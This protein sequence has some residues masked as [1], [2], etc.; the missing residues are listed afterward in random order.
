M[1][2]KKMLMLAVSAIFC[3]AM[4]FPAM[5]DTIS[6]ISMRI[7]SNI[8]AGDDDSDV[9]V[10]TDS[11]KYSVEKVNVT[12]T[13]SRGWDEGDRPKLTIWI[14]AE[15][16]NTFSSNFSKSDVS[17]KGDG[18]TVNF[19][20]R[21]KDYITVNVTLDKLGSS[22]NDYDLDVS[23]L[24]WDSDT[25]EA[26][27]DEANDAKKYEVRL[28]RDDKSVTTVTTSSSSYDFS[29]YFTKK[30]SYTFQVRGVYNSSNKGSWEESDELDV[31][32]REAS[33][34]KENGRGNYTS[35]GD[36]VSG[37]GGPGDT[38][39]SSGA[40]LKDNTGWW[41]CNADRSYPVSQW[42]YINNYW[43]F[44]NDKGYMVTGWVQWKGVWYYCSESGAMLTNT[45]T[46]DGYRVD[47]NGAWIQ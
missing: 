17:I 38:N 18:G 23:G 40:W 2:K 16:G 29:G 44:F 22:D 47:G 42:Q 33:D 13:P 4:A 14:Y 19:V 34:I 45:T 26:S 36:S 20:S 39:K 7:E 31:T 8:E 32:S 27:W 5:A 10:T 46:P 37:N 24:E 25:G 28:Y 41:Y 30:G 11:S 3:L 6:S 21:H 9:N 43:Y 35:S 1:T 15:G 12:N